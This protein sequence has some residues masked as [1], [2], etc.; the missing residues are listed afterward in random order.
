MGMATWVL[1]QRL[2]TPR[3]R[4]AG[5]RVEQFLPSIKFVESIIK[6][7][8]TDGKSVKLRIGW[9]DDEVYA[10][11]VVKHGLERDYT[12]TKPKIIYLC[13]DDGYELIKIAMSQESFYDVY[14]QQIYSIT[15]PHHD[16]EFTDHPPD[17]TIQINGFDFSSS[18][19]AGG[20][21]ITRL[22]TPYFMNKEKNN[23]ELHFKHL[24]R[25]V[26]EVCE[27]VARDSSILPNELEDMKH[28]LQVEDKD[29]EWTPEESRAFASQACQWWY[30][31][32]YEGDKDEDD[33]YKQLTPLLRQ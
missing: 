15:D 28:L 21:E 30:V 16:D 12:G 17:T 8:Y 14:T 22:T 27:H 7:L 33:L 5:L 4:M 26:S 23:R 24:S 3:P 11:C 29:E 18:F 2:N 1:T 19:S 13:R 31:E 32:K 6:D 9:G 10:D 20:F 25:V